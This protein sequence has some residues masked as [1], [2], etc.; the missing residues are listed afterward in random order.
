MFARVPKPH[1]AD[2]T[3]VEAKTAV[4]ITAADRY[5]TSPIRDA[6]FFQRENAATKTTA[7]KASTGT[8]KRRLAAVT[9]QTRYETPSHSAVFFITGDRRHRKTKAHAAATNSAANLRSVRSCGA[10]TLDV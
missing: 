10:P 4:P 8:A 7:V 5:N 9:S 3:A 6:G 2:K 1:G